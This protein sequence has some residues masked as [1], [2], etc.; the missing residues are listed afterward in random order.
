MKHAIGLA[1]F[2]I[3]LNAAADVL[4][5][6]TPSIAKAAD[7][8]EA[9]FV[10]G[11]FTVSRED[12]SVDL[13]VNYTCG[14]SAES[15]VNYK[16][17]SGTVVIPAGETSAT[18]TVNPY[19]AAPYDAP[20]TLTLTLA[21]GDYILPDPAPS[22]SVVIANSAPPVGTNAWVAAED[23]LASVASNWSA[24][25]VP[26][27]TDNILLDECYSTAQ[28]TWDCPTESVPDT[29]A[30]WTQN[31]S[32]TGRVVMPTTRTGAFTLFTVA[33]DATLNGGE[34]WRTGN[35]K[36]D[37]STAKVWLNVRVDGN[38]VAGG[39][40]TFN[41]AAAGYPKQ[42]GISQG[43]E[44]GSTGGAHGG[45]GGGGTYGHGTVYGD[46]RNPITLGSG[47]YGGDDGGGGSVVIDVG[48][49][50]MLNGTV[51]ADAG[52]GGTGS[53][54]SGGSVWIRAKTM[55]GGATGVVTANGGSPSNKRA[56]GGAGRI[57]IQLSDPTWTQTAFAENFTGTIRAI[58]GLD[59]KGGTYA[60]V[61]GASGTIYI[62]TAGDDGK[63]VMRLANRVRASGLD[64]H[65][66][67]TLVANE[68]TW[69]VSRLDM[70]VNGRVGVAAG[71][72]LS[73]PSFSAITGDGSSECLF[74]FI[75]GTVASGIKHDTL[76]ADGFKIAVY[77]SS[78]F[79]SHRLEI[80]AD[81]GLAVSADSTFTVGS[82]KVNGVKLAG[83]SYV[84]NELT[85]TYPN[86]SGAG[87]I[88]VRGLAVGFTVIVR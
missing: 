22:A 64:A 6:G 79:E 65:N 81:S 41:G 14:G 77:A 60:R 11:A 78:N 17:L 46:Y 15:G 55:H 54:Q 24:G 3:A 45:L 62:E 75:G 72:T 66:A 47:Q 16:P 82:L 34:W 49:D 48:G 52:N 86:V 36:G 20:T 2:S 88:V 10:A 37:N 42:R 57:S 61:P 51:S 21:E 30:S 73:V 67:V 70:T 50:F 69:D 23:G 5:N 68:V 40:F 35:A 59:S 83:G 85:E 63:G 56:G 76:V 1:V 33:G 8:D 19:F 18:I 87:T 74:A 9:G 32:Y 31:A 58:G 29:V 38:L 12:S 25:R 53:G 43:G 4:Y 84:A 26:T 7:A 13:P 39:G 28:L 44:K 80:P 71:G 27:A